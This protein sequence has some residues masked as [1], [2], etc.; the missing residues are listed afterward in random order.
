MTTNKEENTMTTNSNPFEDDIRVIGDGKKDWAVVSLQGHFRFNDECPCVIYSRL[1]TREAAE[2]A[3]R[4]AMLGL[5]DP[6]HGCP[7]GSGEVPLAY[8]HAV[9][10]VLRE[11]RDSKVEVEDDVAFAKR[12]LRVAE[13]SLQKYFPEFDGELPF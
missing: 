13:Y 12:I 7:Y 6:T 4:E 8:F 10:R 1:A 5:S 11:I 9:G 3:A 2:V